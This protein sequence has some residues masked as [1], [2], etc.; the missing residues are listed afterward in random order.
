[1]AR[2]IYQFSKYFTCINSGTQETAVIRI[3]TCP[4]WTRGVSS[5][6]GDF[7]LEDTLSHFT[8]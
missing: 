2:N 4:V 8:L 6:Y 7:L 3:P 5:E 1:M